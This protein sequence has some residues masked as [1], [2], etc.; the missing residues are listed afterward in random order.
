M[1]NEMTQDSLKMKTHQQ[2]RLKKLL[3]CQQTKIIWKTELKN[4]IRSGQANKF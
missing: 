1:E 4:L 3:Y 2:F